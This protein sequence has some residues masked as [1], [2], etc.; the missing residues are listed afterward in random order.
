MDCF[1]R[2]ISSAPDATVEV[3]LRER[4]G[5]DLFGPLHDLKLTERKKRCVNLS[6]YNYLGFGGV[7]EPLG[8]REG[9]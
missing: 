6:S 3:V 8:R 5:G 7:D 2:P 4:P 9:R 1:A